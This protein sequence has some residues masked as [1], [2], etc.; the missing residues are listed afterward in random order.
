[1]KKNL[2][3]PIVLFVVCSMALSSEV[4][5]GLVQ[6]YDARYP[7]HA[8]HEIWA[9][10]DPY[11]ADG[12]LFAV[13]TGSLIPKYIS[14][15]SGGGYDLSFFLDSSNSAKDTGGVINLESSFIPDYDDD[16]SVEIWF[17]PD[18]LP[19]GN[20]QQ[21]LWSTQSLKIGRASCR[22]RV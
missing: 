15:V 22:E 17:R 5:N 16:Y 14:K 7:G 4:T 12:G 18:G 21:S 13:G 1:M 20:P 2:L 6:K 19:V 10:V 3:M 11:G 8:P 9:P